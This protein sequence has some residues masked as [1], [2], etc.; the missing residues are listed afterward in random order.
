MYRRLGTL[1]LLAGALVAA[2]ASAQDDTNTTG[3]EV[4][5]EGDDSDTI[6]KRIAL[7]IRALSFGLQDAPNF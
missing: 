6:I 4:A 5:V 3:D 2:P 7:V 1:G